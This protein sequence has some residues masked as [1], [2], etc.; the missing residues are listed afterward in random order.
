MKVHGAP[1]VVLVI[2]DN[3]YGLI[4]VL[5]YPIDLV[6]RKRLEFMCWTLEAYTITKFLLKGLY[7][8]W[9]CVELSILQVCLEE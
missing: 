2:N 3:P 9:S 4:F 6:H 5:L 7:E 1:C 8:E